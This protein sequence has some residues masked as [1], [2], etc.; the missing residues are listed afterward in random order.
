MPSP[1]IN[2]FVPSLIVSCPANGTSATLPLV[3]SVTLAVTRFAALTATP[4]VP[5]PVSYVRI[6]PSTTAQRTIV[7]AAV[8]HAHTPCTTVP[9][10]VAPSRSQ[11]GRPT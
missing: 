1:V 9:A 2:V 3:A 4:H 11:P 7:P 5:A 8:V 10:A 6:S